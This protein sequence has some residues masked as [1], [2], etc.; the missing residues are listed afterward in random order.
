MNKLIK[1]LTI[2]M[3]LAMAASGMLTIALA[4]E[5]MTIAVD[6]PEGV[7]L[8]GDTFTVTVMVK[9][10]AGFT[11]FQMSLDYDPEVLELTALKAGQ[12]C[13]GSFIANL[14]SGIVVYTHNGGTVRQD[15]ILFTATF[16]VYD[17]VDTEQT[18]VGVRVQDLFGQQGS[19]LTAATAAATIALHSHD[20]GTAWQSNEQ[21][22]WLACAC[23]DIIQRLPH[24][25]DDGTLTTPPTCTTSGVRLDTCTACGQ[26]KTETVEPLNHAPEKGWKYDENRH[27]HACPCDRRT[28]VADHIW[29]EPVVVKEPTATEAG[30]RVSRCTECPAERYESI[31]AKGPA[32]AP[33]TKPQ[34]DPQPDPQPE[35]DTRIW[36][37]V[38]LGAVLVAAAAVVAVRWMRRK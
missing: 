4:A 17:W 28:D 23:G 9:E 36:I 24:T 10:N 34:P 20:Y 6:G 7:H 11:G 21:E 27:W 35:K 22:H 37:Y 32:P 3:A 12:L 31:P 16:T 8:P 29:S 13:S 33:E 14:Q 18:V 25:W 38:A 1:I 30:E 15:G 19:T 26:T 2:L 5:E